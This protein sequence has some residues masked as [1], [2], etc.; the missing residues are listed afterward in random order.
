MNCCESNGRFFARETAGRMHAITFATLDTNEFFRTEEPAKNGNYSA[1]HPKKTHPNSLPF[2]SV[3]IWVGSFLSQSTQRIKQELTEMNSETNQL[4][5][6]VRF[7][8]C[9][10]GLLINFR[11]RMLK[12]EL[13]RLAL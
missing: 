7:S 1:P 6:A 5:E 8:R 9:R 10:V 4:T 11:A 2:H 12:D 13:R 3:I